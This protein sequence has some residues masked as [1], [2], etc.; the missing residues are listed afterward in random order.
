MYTFEGL[1]YFHPDEEF[2]Q[3]GKWV[4]S[5]PAPERMHQ[6]FMRL[7]DFAREE[8]GVAFIVTSSYRENDEG[9]HGR[10]M[11]VDIR[12]SLAVVRFKIIQ[13]ALK[14]GIRGIGVYDRHVHLD[15][16]ET[17]MIWV[18]TSNEEEE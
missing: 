11:A 10:G 14:M 17:G 3:G 9:F 16:R 8:A 7:L 4:R 1:K 2:S 13:A 6:R 12:C 15:Y 18:G 5:F